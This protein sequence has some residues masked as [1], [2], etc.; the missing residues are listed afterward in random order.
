MKNQENIYYSKIF[1]NSI[2]LIVLPIISTIIF[3]IFIFSFLLTLHF[4]YSFS[5]IILILLLSSL[6]ISS[7]VLKILNIVYA[8]KLNNNSK[9][10]EKFD[11]IILLFTLLSFFLPVFLFHF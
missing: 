5:F 4:F 10:N 7:F 8:T 9:F 6:S 1:K 11:N 3:F 2:A